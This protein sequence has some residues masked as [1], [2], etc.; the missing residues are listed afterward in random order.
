MANALFD[1]Q[2]KQLKPSKRITVRVLADQRNKL[3]MIARERNWELSD[4]VKRMIGNFLEEYEKLPKPK[5]TKFDF[6]R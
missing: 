3:D 4:M 6:V 2:A 1:L 5:Q